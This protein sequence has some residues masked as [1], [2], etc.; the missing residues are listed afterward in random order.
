MSCTK[1]ELMRMKAHYEN[2][3]E[4]EKSLISLSTRRIQDARVRLGA[5]TTR[6]Q[7]SCDHVWCKDPAYID[8]RTMF[9]C[10]KCDMTAH[11]SEIRAA[12][13]AKCGGMLEPVA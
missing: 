8:E 13:L 10:H 9:V 7:E 3:I 6:L 12:E 5:I 11:Y 4:A 1:E 2:V